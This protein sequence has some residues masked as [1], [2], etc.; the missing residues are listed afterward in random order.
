M[1][2]AVSFKLSNSLRFTGHFPGGPALTGTRMSLF[3]FPL[4]LRV[5]EVVVKTGAITRA[6]LQSKCHH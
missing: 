3:W 6:K 2:I 1:D 4:E 5:M